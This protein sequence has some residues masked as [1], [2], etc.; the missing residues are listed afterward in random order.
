MLLACGSYGQ[1]PA[2]F[3][4]SF[5][6]FLTSGFSRPNGPLTSFHQAFLFSVSEGGR[7]A[8]TKV[9][10]LFPLTLPGN[11]LSFVA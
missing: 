10:A 2:A 3:F 1:E 7:K 4:P 8:C 9:Y 11:A 6:S 5:F